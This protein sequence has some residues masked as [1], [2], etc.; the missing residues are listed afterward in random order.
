ML[1]KSVT[2]TTSLRAEVIWYKYVDVANWNK[3][4]SSIESSELF[5]DFIEGTKGTLKPVGGPKTGFVLTTLTKFVYFANR[6]SLLLAHI[7][8]EHAIADD[9]QIR[10]VTHTISIGGLLSPIFK[11]ILGK[12]LSMGLEESVENLLK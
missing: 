9:E 5:G 3:W 11:I 12:K 6:S 8:F 1:I 4:D 2:R 7:D 10:T